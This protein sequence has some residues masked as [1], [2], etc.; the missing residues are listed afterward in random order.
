MLLHRCL[1]SRSIQG[2][3]AKFHIPVIEERRTVPMLITFI[4][5]SMDR[6]P[7]ITSCPQMQQVADVDDKGV[8]GHGNGSPFARG[9]VEDL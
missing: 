5:N 9:W 3:K 7:V 4:D 6:A 8:F 1:S 2:R